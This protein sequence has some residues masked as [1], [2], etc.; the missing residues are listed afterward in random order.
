MNVHDPASPFEVEAQATARTIAMLLAARAAS[1]GAGNRRALFA[2][3]DELLSH[4]A[5]DFASAGVAS[6][7]PA[8]S[9]A[10][11]GNG[12]RVRLARLRMRNWK[13][14]ESADI[15]LPDG[16]EGRPL[17]VIVGPN[18]F[19]KSSILEAF[20][21]GLFGR[22][23][24]SDLGQF[25]SGTGGRI[26]AR[27]SY[28]WVIHRSLHR[29][30]R[31]LAD[32][33]CSV[34]LDFATSSGPVQVERRWYFDERGEPIEDD[35]EVFVRLG[36]D[37]FLLRPP[38]GVAARDWQQAEIERLVMPAALAPFFIFDGEQIERRADRQL[39]DQVRS[40]LTRLLGL[41]DLAGLM[42]D[43]RDYT[44]DRE[45]G[46]AEADA[47]AID[48]LRANVERRITALTA[49]ELEL[50]AVSA[51]VAALREERDR[52]LA[53]LSSTAP[54]SHADLQRDLE[55]EHRLIA[56]RH[57]HDRELSA[58]LCEDGPLLL[59]GTALLEATADD[60]DAE[61]E[62]TNVVTLDLR[63]M[64]AL[65][66]RFATLDPPLE[67]DMANSLRVRFEA[68]CTVEGNAPNS[69]PLA[70]G[71]D[72]ASRRAIV[73]RLRT[74]AEQARA[75]LRTVS[76]AI[77]A[78]SLQLAALRRTVGEAD[79]LAL[80]RVSAQAELALASDAIRQAEEARTT[81][82]GRVA[83]LRQALDPQRQEL[84]RREEGLREA[85]PRL[86]MAAAARRIVA[87]LDAHATEIAMAE[88]SRFATAVTAR[89][90]EMSHKDQIA[91]IEITSDGRVTLTDQFG[92][93]VS[94]YPLS[95]GE[96]QLFAMALV[97]AVGDLAGDRLPLIVD[98][99]LG[100]LDSN[101]R[102]TVMDMLSKRRSQ[103]IML[104]Q[105]E[106]ISEAY[107]ASLAP[108]LALAAELRHAT[109]TQTGVGVSRVAP[110]GTGALQ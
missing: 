11:Q 6:R 41:D 45:R 37:R 68:A 10:L 99:P 17:V 58:A 107:L 16:G 49:Q 57:Q 47:A 94:D 96:N 42:A 50:S 40:A 66:R 108:V 81:I 93:D 4:V 85:D 67:P 59:A 101:H 56:E 63:E 72:R 52:A 15:V 48:V 1:S 95:A 14:F 5:D 75:R 79:G 110:A 33:S 74:A 18:G 46:F 103:T 24:V 69:N 51:E 87:S 92:R 54:A 90:R 13:S 86:R 27:R 30:A 77:E 9:G 2:R 78:N 43:L 100:R 55:A 91:R 60:L 106:E 7:A 102:Q 36:E 12:G 32:G 22:R 39:A 19:G 70:K 29:S 83:A 76:R 3:M 104:T 21:L 80:A 82:V 35:E 44:K 109:D 53:R 88:H 89:F 8:L 65:W 26:G 25:A 64:E 31:A 97:A 28:R 62:R 98:T 105:P 61:A 23:A 73:L 84:A 20:S 38:P 34:L 71:L